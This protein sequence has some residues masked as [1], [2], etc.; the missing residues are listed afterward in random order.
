[1]LSSSRHGRV[2][3]I[4]VA[5]I[6]LSTASCRGDRKD[7][8][9]EQRQAQNQSLYARDWSRFPA[10]VER[11]TRAEVIALGDIHGGY[12]RLVNLLSIGGLIKRDQQK[13]RGYI[14]SGGNRILVCTGDLI[15]KGDR[16]LDVIDLMMALQPQALASGGEVVITIGNH[17]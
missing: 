11:S 3:I 8:K 9:H 2:V 5:A 6:L 16:S 7:R 13:Q 10:V 17:E 4:L 14:W 1:V 12:E 15:D